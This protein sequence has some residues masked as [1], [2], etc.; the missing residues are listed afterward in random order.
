[1]AKE[2][3][4]K[5]KILRLTVIL[6]IL[7]A[8]GLLAAHFYMKNRPEDPKEEYVREVEYIPQ[9][10]ADYVRLN[11]A[12]SEEMMG[13]DYWIKLRTNSG[14]DAGLALLSFSQIAKYNYDNRRMI[15]SKDVEYSLDEI[16]DEFSAQIAAQFIKDTYFV[17][18]N[19]E[20]LYINGSS[21]D[22]LYWDRLIDN[23]NL[24]ALDAGVRIRYGFSV[25]RGTLKRF[26]TDDEIYNAGMN[27]YYDVLVQSDLQPFMPVAVLHESA[28]GEWYYVLAYGYGGW[29]RKE[30][31]AL[32]ESREDWLARQNPEA[33]LV[34]TGKEI[35]LS[36]DPYTESLS[37]LLVPMGTV[38]P[39]ASI[40]ETPADIHNRVSYG[41][42]VAKLPA[43]DDEGSLVDEYIL[44]PVSEDVNLGYM[45]Y[46]EENVAKLSFKHLGTMYGW[47]GSYNAQDCSGYVREVYACF[48]FNLPRVART[49]VDYAC[50]KNL[51]V[52]KLT[53]AEKM[54]ILKDA[55]IGTLLYFQG[56]IMMYVGTTD[57]MPYCIS[58]AGNITT[59]INEEIVEQQVNTVVLTNMIDTKMPDGRTWIEGITKIT[60]P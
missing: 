51:D 40:E 36:T 32:C 22:R 14:A 11:N 57:D 25:S 3:G 44:I 27:L 35:R 56:H 19:P 38:L 5:G 50:E 41:N 30:N 1:M 23:L 6:V 10:P 33:F 43:R 29:T 7:S 21:T 12:V 59:L 52:A 60:I 9:N 58:A 15:K 42:Y 48:G 46:S 39:I 47:G 55:P 28:D 49:Q 34:V 37:D 17:P 31:V 45:P 20:T 2:K 8:G 24:D 4:I 18:E 53:F 54:E 26:P 13:P 16:G